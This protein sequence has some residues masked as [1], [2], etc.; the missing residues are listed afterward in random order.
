MPTATLMQPFADLRG[1]FAEVVEPGQRS[2]ALEPEDALEERRRPVANRSTRSIVAA[3]LGDQAA[4][5]QA[6]DG[7]VGGDAADA[8]DLGPAARA[9]VGNDRERLHRRLR[10]ATLDRALE[11]ATAGLGGLARAAEGVAAGDVLQHDPAAPLAVA[12]G[13]QPE[14]KL[15]PL[16]V[17]RGRVGELL[18]RQRRRGDHEQRLERPGELV[19]RVCGDQAERTIHSAV[20]SFAFADSCCDSTAASWGVAG[21]ALAGGAVCEYGPPAGATSAAS[22]N[23]GAGLCTA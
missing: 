9:E 16:G 21:D 6:G 5:E 19:D 17:V 1:A 23:G 22:G 11:E 7:R 20:L 10:E 12:I 2:G 8:S 3:C 14:R 15:D 18:D 4:L 13:E